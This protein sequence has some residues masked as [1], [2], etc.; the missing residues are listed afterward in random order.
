MQSHRPGTGHPHRI[1]KSSPEVTDLTK[2][3]SLFPAKIKYTHSASA[4]HRLFHV[5]RVFVHIRALEYTDDEGAEKWPS[6]NLIEHMYL[7]RVVP[8]LFKLMN[9][10]GSLGLEL[11]S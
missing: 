4:Q 10:T 7:F 2:Q 5:F 9:Q 1:S 6:I 8:V 11:K 3:A